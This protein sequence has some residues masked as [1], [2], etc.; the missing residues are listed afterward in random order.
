MGLFGAEFTSG[1][2]I[3]IFCCLAQFISVC[4]GPLEYLLIMGRQN[5]HL[6]NNLVLALINIGCNIILIKKYGV[7]GAVMTLGISMFLYNF[8]RLVEVYIIYRLFPYNKKFL[9]VFFIAFVVTVVAA[10]TNK[11]L[12]GGLLSGAVSFVIVA[13]GFYFLLN[14]WGLDEEDRAVVMLVKR[15]VG[16]IFMRDAS[17]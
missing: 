3:L 14:L 15:K 10:F 13:G 5:L 17:S 16:G 9:K 6:I 8:V 4:T 7:L 11:W 1:K 12:P 2:N